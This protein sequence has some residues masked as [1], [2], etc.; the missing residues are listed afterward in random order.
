MKSDKTAENRRGSPDVV[1]KRRAA[2]AF[3]EAL[4]GRAAPARDGRTERRRRRLLKE[5]ADGVAGRGKRELKPVDVLSRVRELLELGE[6]LAAI[7]K[8]CPARRAVEPT[9]A[10]VEGIRRLHE[11]YKFPLEAY[12]FVGVGDDV[13]RAA[14]V[15][16][17]PRAPA[18]RATRPRR[19]ASPGIAAAKPPQARARGPRRGVA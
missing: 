18:V 12:R 16:A 7:K 2:R 13:L 5:L 14:G 1:E 9:P 3:N 10:V 4:L 11:A 19:P 17:A 6:P 15:L 8:A